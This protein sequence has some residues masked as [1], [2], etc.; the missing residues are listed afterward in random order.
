MTP[1]VLI[2]LHTE[3]E[4][5]GSITAFLDQ[6]QARI[7]TV[8]LFDAE[9]LPPDPCVFSLIVAMGGTMNVYETTAF[10]FLRNEP[11][12]LRAAMTA[13]VPVLGVCLGAQLIARAC[14]APV[15][16]SPQPEVGWFPITLTPAAA[17]EP[18]FAG[19]PSELTVLQWHED[20]ALLPDGAVL[21]AS[22]PACPHQAFRVGSALALQ[23]HVEMTHALLS[24]WTHDKKHL[25]HIAEDFPRFGVRLQPHATR[26]YENLWRDV[27]VHAAQA[28]SELHAD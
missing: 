6:Q 7:T 26:I 11:A 20:M 14:D 16:K 1:H 27:T 13:H 5:P 19:I 9:P 17:Q 4:E 24:Q 23:F 15:I 28:A 25:R 18:A 10:S 8:K 22:S 21:L 3:T 2:L 12:F